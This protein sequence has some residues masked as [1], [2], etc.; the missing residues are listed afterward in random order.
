MML[1]KI[2]FGKEKL[3]GLMGKNKMNFANKSLL[4]LYPAMNNVNLKEKK[5]NLKIK[6]LILNQILKYFSNFNHILIIQY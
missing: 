1:M 2:K 3:N 6:A 5:L 4:V